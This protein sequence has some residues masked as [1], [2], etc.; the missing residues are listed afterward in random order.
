MW[1]LLTLFNWRNSCKR[2]YFEAINF[3]GKLAKDISSEINHFYLFREIYS[4]EKK[5][6]IQIFFVCFFIGFYMDI[7]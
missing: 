5:L 2:I 6:I 7:C 1:T 3:Y 4:C